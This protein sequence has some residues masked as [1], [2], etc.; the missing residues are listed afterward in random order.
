[1]KVCNTYRIN[2]EEYQV[3]KLIESVF[4]LSN[5]TSVILLDGLVSISANTLQNSNVK[6]VY[7]PATL[8]LTGQSKNF[9]HYFRDIKKLYYGGSKK[10][11]NLLTN[12]IDRSKVDIKEIIYYSKIE[13]LR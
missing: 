8:Q 12:G 9:Y 3:T 2:N 10:Q 13:D 6:Y 5:V 1:M 11:W 4:F 7:I